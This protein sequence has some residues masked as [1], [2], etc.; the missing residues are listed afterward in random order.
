M[1]LFQIRPALT[2][3][4][5]FDSADGT[6]FV[7]KLENNDGNRTLLYVLSGVMI[8]I[9][10]ASGALIALIVCYF[11]RNRDEGK[12]E[13]KVYNIALDDTHSD[14]SSAESSNENDASDDMENEDHSHDG[15]DSEAWDY[16]IGPGMVEHIMDTIVDLDE[17]SLEDEQGSEN[18]T[19]DK[20]TDDLNSSHGFE[21]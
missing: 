1:E 6:S 20:C 16:S 14:P 7:R 17:E 10:L 8:G 3:L 15:L 12:V 13:N 19:I 2:P 9:A 5:T 11:G 4:E 21:V 18:S